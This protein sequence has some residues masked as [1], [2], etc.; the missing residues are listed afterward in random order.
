MKSQLY[1][2]ALILPITS[3]LMLCTSGCSSNAAS[4]RTLYQPP[5]LHLLKGRPI[6]TAE[7]LYTPQVDELWHSGERYAARERE[8]WALAAALAEAREQNKESQ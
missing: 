5:I 3:A 8:V 4:Q 7:G 1:A 6:Q 2:A